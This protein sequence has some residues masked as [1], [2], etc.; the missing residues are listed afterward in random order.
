MKTPWYKEPWAWFVFILPLSAVVAGITTVII[1][2]T[3]ADS[4]VV[5]D[6]YK[7]GKAINL[8]LSKIKQAQKL[9]IEFALKLSNNELVIKPTGIEKQFPLLNVNFYHPTQQEKD[10]YLAMTADGNGNFRQTL[11]HDVRGKWRITI[12]PFENHWKIQNTI[13]LPQSDFIEITPK[14]LEAR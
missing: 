9:G 12:S 6:Y 8:E 11:D 2:N 4:L 1:A 10:F 5:G 13:T 14:P 3:D 7:K